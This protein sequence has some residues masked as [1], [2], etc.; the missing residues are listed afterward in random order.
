MDKPTVL[1]IEEFKQKLSDVVSNS[2][3]PAF[4]LEYI[5]K[6]LYTEVH[7]ISE[8]VKLKEIQEKSKNIIGFSFSAKVPCHKVLSKSHITNLTFV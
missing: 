3:L 5:I 7:N 2:E 8:Q 4:I 6:D 1:S